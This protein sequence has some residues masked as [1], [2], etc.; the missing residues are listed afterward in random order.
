MAHRNED[1]ENIKHLTAN[2]MAV[3]MQQLEKSKETVFNFNLDLVEEIKNTEKEVNQ[4]ELNIDQECLNILA[5]YTPVAVDLRFI[6]ATLKINS[7]LERLGDYAESI[8]KNTDHTEA[9]LNEEVISKLNIAE[10]YSQALSSFQDVSDAFRKENTKLARKV[11]DKDVLLN[12]YN[13][14]ANTTIEALIKSDPTNTQVYLRALSIVRKLERVGDMS[15][16]IAEEIIFY[17][18][19]KVLKHKG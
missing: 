5:L 19:A 13:K 9:T 12:E 4:M 16:K 6:F 7:E 2:M 11:F 14:K 8:A 15:K 1:F 18:E 3:V 10:M 17:L